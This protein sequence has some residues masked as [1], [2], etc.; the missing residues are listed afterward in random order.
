MFGLKELFVEFF[1]P[2]S[3]CPCSQTWKKN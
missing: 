1:S 3:N 2:T